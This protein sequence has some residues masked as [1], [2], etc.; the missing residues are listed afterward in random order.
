MKV[1]KHIRMTKA[2]ICLGKA[3]TK[4]SL[5]K[6]IRRILMSKNIAALLNYNIR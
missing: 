4:S 5:A 6:Q 1:M 3:E 2:A